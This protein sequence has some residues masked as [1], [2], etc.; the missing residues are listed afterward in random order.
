MKL[1]VEQRIEL[2]VKMYMELKDRSE[3]F[4]KTNYPTLPEEAKHYLKEEYEKHRSA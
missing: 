2:E 3:D 1:T 4:F